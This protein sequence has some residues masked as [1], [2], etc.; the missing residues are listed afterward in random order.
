M[1]LCPSIFILHVN[2]V[3]ED[4]TYHLFLEVDDDFLYSNFGKIR[5]YLEKLSTNCVVPEDG[6]NSEKQISCF[7]LVM[8]THIE[9]VDTLFIKITGIT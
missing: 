1:E 9:K 5:V 2:A 8:D 7:I 4:K 3:V 6:Q